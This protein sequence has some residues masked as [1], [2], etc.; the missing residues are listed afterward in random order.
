M[1]DGIFFVFC[2]FASLPLYPMQY[3]QNP[4]I[5]FNRFNESNL[6]IIVDLPLQL[7]AQDV[8]GIWSGTIQTQ[9]L[10]WN[11]NW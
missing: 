5:F 4:S 2:G 8:S 10:T 9:G 7:F 1:R 6:H 11:M 3:P